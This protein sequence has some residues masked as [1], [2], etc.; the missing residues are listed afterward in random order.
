VLH[1]AAT[2]A[3][4][5]IQTKMSKVFLFIPRPVFFV[6]MSSCNESDGARFCRVVAEA[7][8][9][10]ARRVV[11]PSVGREYTIENSFFGK[12][13][14]VEKVLSDNKCTK[15]MVLMRALNGDMSL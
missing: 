14:C 3:F 13:L 9:G 4:K 5:N 2:D 6:E 12:S 15:Y 8:V 1:S 11:I 7:I 10:V